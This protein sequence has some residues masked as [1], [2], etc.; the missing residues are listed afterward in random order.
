VISTVD[1][2]S[3]GLLFKDVSF[4]LLVVDVLKDVE[5]LRL[6]PLLAVDDLLV[7]F[8]DYFVATMAQCSISLSLWHHHFFIMVL[9]LAMTLLGFQP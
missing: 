9:V 6:L 1:D 7:R 8:L 2:I 5:A 3:V 4:S